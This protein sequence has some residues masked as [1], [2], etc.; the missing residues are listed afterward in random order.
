MYMPLCLNEGMLGSVRHLGCLGLAT[1]WA[2]R[3]GTLGN[4]TLLVTEFV[5]DGELFTQAGSW[6]GWT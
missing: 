6:V 1:A 5:S 3:L 4:N 2:R